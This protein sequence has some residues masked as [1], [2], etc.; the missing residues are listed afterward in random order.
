[1]PGGQV[2]AVDRRRRVLCLVDIPGG[3]DTMIEKYKDLEALAGKL[4][5]AG[6]AFPAFE[7]GSSTNMPSPVP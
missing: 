2:P 3:G 5:Q 4:E 1:P 7:A 6:F